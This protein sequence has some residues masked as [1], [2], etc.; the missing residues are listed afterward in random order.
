MH[1]DWLS[2]W[3]GL[4]SFQA[5][6]TARGTA[7]E[8]NPLSRSV[9]IGKAQQGL[10]PGSARTHPRTKG[11]SPSTDSG[12][13]PNLVKDHSQ[14]EAGL[15]ELLFDGS[16]Y[17][18]LILRTHFFSELQHSLRDLVRI[19]T[20]VHRL[21]SL[22]RNL[23]IERSVRDLFGV[24]MTLPSPI[25]E[26]HA[27]FLPRRKLRLEPFLDGGG[28]LL[29]RLDAGD[30]LDELR[31]PNSVEV[32]LKRLANL[33]GLKGLLTEICHRNAVAAAVVVRSAVQRLMNVPCEMDDEP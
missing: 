16:S 15:C 19:G 24:L 3:S 12:R 20:G 10:V 28:E 25:V 17:E 26:V 21:G 4:G 2:G 5:P 7:G 11:L 32:E 8:H 1:L 29:D 27:L 14:A 31:V 13:R 6:R 18:G 33:I 23:S 30:A 22:D 9:T